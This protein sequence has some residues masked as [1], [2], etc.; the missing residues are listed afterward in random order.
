MY[1]LSYVINQSCQKPRTIGLTPI[2]EDPLNID[3]DRS[4]G[5]V[6]QGSSHFTPSKNLFESYIDLVRIL[7]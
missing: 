2:K 3:R 6:V 4:A 7:S 5:N 1:P